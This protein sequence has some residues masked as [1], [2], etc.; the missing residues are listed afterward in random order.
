M[1]N[2]QRGSSVAWI[3]LVI[4]VVLAIALYCVNKS[5]TRDAAM[6]SPTA[7]SSVPVMTPTPSVTTS[8]MTSVSSDPVVKGTASSALVLS[9]RLSS[10]GY[11]SKTSY[12][13]L[14]TLITDIR[15]QNVTGVRVVGNVLVSGMSGY[16]INLNGKPAV[17]VE[18]DSKIYTITYNN[19]V[20]PLAPTEKVALSDIKLN[21]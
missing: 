15:A 14:A 17:W 7:S 3:V 8:P 21:W 9:N 10:Y 20:S 5:M 13:N 16:E 1:K 19:K 6:P 12:L 4:V 11:K 18:K 2:V